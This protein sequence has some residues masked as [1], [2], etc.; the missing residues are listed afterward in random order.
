MF[1]KLEDIRRIRL[2]LGLTQRKLALLV[3]VSTSLINQIETG[4]SK[5][6]YETARRI[7]EV[8][9][10]LEAKNSPK[11]GDICSRSVVFVSA[12]DT[13]ASA[14]E[15]MRRYG[16]SQLPVLN[17]DKIIGLITEEGIMKRIGLWFAG[18]LLLSSPAVA[19][20]A[21]ITLKLATQQQ[22]LLP[23]EPLWVAITLT[24]QGP[25]SAKLIGTCGDV[26]GPA[27]YG[28][29][30]KRAI[31]VQGPDGQ[32]K[33]GGWSPSCIPV[34]P[35][36][37]GQ[38]IVCATDLG[39]EEI[40]IFQ[41]PGTYEIWAE[42]QGP[43][44]QEGPH[45]ADEAAPVTN[46]WKGFAKSNIVTVTV[47]APTG[48]DREAYDTYLKPYATEAKPLLN[49]Y[50]G[51][52]TVVANGQQITRGVNLLDAILQRF[53][54]STYAGY[55]LIHTGPGGSLS[56]FEKWWTMTARQRDDAW[57]V[58]Q[59]ASPARQEARRQL[60][61][62]NYQGFVQR[63]QAFLAIHPDFARAD[64]LRKELANTL[65]MLDQRDEAVE[66]V[67][68]LATMK[69]PVADEARA[70]LSQ[71]KQSTPNP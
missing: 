15:V 34:T 4:R 45:M 13:A 44:P 67:H 5:P 29:T 60:V 38:S 51:R 58:P 12:K 18:L 37:A 26:M 54:T 9:S 24:N 19:Q 2:R 68:K 28:S 10:M 36:P 70:V 71:A 22:Q 39:G 31:R 61:R 3:G 25:G 47:V 40:K 55:A 16:F 23:G 41:S 30:C 59:A 6:S 27:D 17:G 56:T 48:V 11:A 33:T 62:S 21:R 66:E 49:A 35:L 46:F 69:G 53:P 50:T 1:P 43:G 64:L 20:Q 57:Y 52:E 7:F 14:A 42:Y 63:A 65:F 8:L 32:V